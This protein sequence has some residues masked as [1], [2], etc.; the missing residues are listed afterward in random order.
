M[1]GTNANGLNSKRDS[2]NNILESE[3]P[4][5]FMVQE[6]KMKRMNQWTINGYELYEKIRKGKG[7]GGIMIG[8]SKNFDIQ[9]V[10]V[11][12]HEEDIEI[13]VVEV[14]FKSITVRFLTA[15]GPQE[16]ASEDI[17]NKFYLTLEEEI[18]R[19]EQ[20]NCALI[21]ELDCNAKLGRGIIEGDPHI[22]SCNGKVLWDIL[23]RRG[24]SVINGSDRCTGTIKRSRMKGGILEKSVLDYVIVNAAAAPYVHCMVIDESKTRSL[25]RYTKGKAV[26][27]DHNLI[28]CTFKIP[29]KKKPL[30]RTEVYRL[31]NVEELQNFKEKTSHTNVFTQCFERE[32]DVQEQGKKWLKTLQKSI[33]TSFK[34]IRIRHNH[35]QKGSMHEKLEERKQILKKMNS[36]SPAERH[37]LENEV[38]VLENELSEEY[39]SKQI[40]KLREH[41]NIITDNDGRVSTAGAWKLRRKILRK[42]PEQ[43][44]S[45]MD[46]NGDLVTN[47]EKIKKIY[48]EAYTDRLKHREML[49][50]LQNLQ[51]IREQ[52][53]QQRLEQAKLNKSP[54]WTM[55]QLEAALSKL[56][57][58]K[59][60]DPMG[61]VNELFMLEN[62]GTDLK[63][64]LLM[65]LNKVK[66]QFKEPE[67]M[68]LANIT[69]FWK[70]KGPKSDIDNE[71]GIFILA[72]LRMI[73]D[74]M[75]Y[76]D[77]RQVVQISDSQVGGRA[78]Y[79][80]RNHLFVVYSIMNS[81][82]N[83]ECPPVDIHLYDLQKCFDGLWLEECCNN[84]YE[85]G[86][87][88]D[89]LAL[90]YEGNRTN[91]VA[92][93]TPGGLTDRVLMERIVMQGGVTGPLCCS[94]Q[95]DCIGKESIENG[96]HL[97]MYKGSVGIPTLAMVDDLLKVSQCGIDA[98]KDNAYVNAKIEQDRQSFNGTKCHQMHVGKCNNFCSPLRAHSAEMNIVDKDK[99]VGDVI[100]R[101]G[102]HAKNVE[103]RRSKGIG[104]C[105]EITAILNDMCLGPHYFLIAVLLRRALLISV[106]LFN[107]ETWL[108][109]TKES[110]KRLESVDLMLLRKVLKTPI[111]TPK[112]SLYLE[113]G[114][115]PLR[116]ILKGKRIMFL[117]HILT[118][119]INSLISRVFWAQVHD[120]GKGDW[121][122]VVRQDLD[123]LGLENLSF[124]D[125]KS[126]S[127]ESLKALIN[128]RINITALEELLS[129]KS[130]LSKV[131]E[132]TYTKLEM[133]QYLLDENLSTRQKQLLFRW[134][135]K[136]TKV[137]WNYGKKDM[138]CPICSDAEDTQDHLLECSALSS[139]SLFN[140]SVDMEYD[141]NLHITRLEAV[142]RKREIILHER[143]KLK[144]VKT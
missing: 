117:H 37:K 135:T 30:P 81:V 61:L 91:R 116:Y 131:S 126:T 64:S 106:L 50:E 67:F 98:V 18:V 111:S 39:K 11:S 43:L 55:D 13:L 125:I 90:I 38:E 93:K 26:P 44:T 99:Y 14:A 101:D 76:N 28:I 104:I 121:C 141:L 83:K 102:K 47:P 112:V 62:I 24:C 70:R 10:V 54:P 15:Y 143:E 85:A 66:D 110:I 5:V 3:K 123:M 71:R 132:L 60:T 16:D 78:E 27:S 31:R 95:T 139:D 51:I 144:N 1:I 82:I 130:K 22:M 97:Y 32:G 7:G 65:L 137:G 133:Q 25:T 140:Q 136:M 72:V 23:E 12:D 129:E 77:V 2:L 48:L 113:T 35:T 122:Q 29:L 127:K 94:V 87:T 46:K 69:S 103:L 57:N 124:S 6:T 53:F 49:P 105:N 74:R 80:I 20:E 75:I 100:S 8:M 33:C 114:C 17:I 56:K 118:R 42:P 36:C 138:L 4:H 134:R 58:G 120:T 88:D 109:L 73:K 96:E 59:A 68:Q 19:C 40:E 41:L 21:A 108:R 115:V 63:E 107:S 34:K 79:S 84:L 89:K 119:D 86:I 45:K 9:P 92:V 128:D 52:L 142:V